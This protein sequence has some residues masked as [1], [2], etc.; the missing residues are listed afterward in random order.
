MCTRYSDLQSQLE[1]ALIE[2]RFLVQ[3]SLQVFF[4]EYFS[5][6]AQGQTNTKVYKKHV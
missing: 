4:V 6:L 1:A 5:H 3:E 2:T